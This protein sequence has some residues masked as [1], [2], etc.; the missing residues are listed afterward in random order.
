MAGLNANLKEMKAR[1]KQN[2]NCVRGFGTIYTL[3]TSLADISASESI[4]NPLFMDPTPTSWSS[5]K[6]A[7]LSIEEVTDSFF[8]EY[9]AFTVA[10][11]IHRPAAGHDWFTDPDGLRLDVIHVLEDDAYGAIYELMCFATRRTEFAVEGEEAK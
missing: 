11:V 5:L 7:G 10:G 8:V 3:H 1:V 4:I 9:T 6:K 2:M